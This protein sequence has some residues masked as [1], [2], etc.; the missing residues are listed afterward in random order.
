MITSMM[1]MIRTATLPNSTDASE[2]SMI[3]VYHNKE[4]TKY[5]LTEK[6]PHLKEI[7]PLLTKVAD[8]STSD[9]DEAFRLTNNIDS[10]WINNHAVQPTAEIISQQGCRST[11]V[12]DVMRTSDGTWYSIALFG[13]I[14]LTEEN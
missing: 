11:W 14:K 2:N 13:F 9:L 7:L 12:G 8:V 6:P 4:F 10:P 3:A 5:T 1:K